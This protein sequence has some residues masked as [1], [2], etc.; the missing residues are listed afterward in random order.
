[1]G[2]RR[3]QLTSHLGLPRRSVKFLLKNS[4]RLVQDRLRSL[5]A[6]YPFFRKLNKAAGQAPVVEAAHKYIC[7]CSDPAHPDTLGVVFLPTPL[8]NDFRYVFFENAAFSAFLLS[9]GEKIL[10]L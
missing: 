8:M 5:Q 3:K 2:H 4:N 10:P 9:V 6:E 1:M 7:I